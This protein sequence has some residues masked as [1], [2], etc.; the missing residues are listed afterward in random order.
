MYTCIKIIS[1]PHSARD[2]ATACPMPLVP[3]VITAVWPS[4]ENEAIVAE[5]VIFNT[6]LN[7]LNLC[8]FDFLERQLTAA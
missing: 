3:P 2:T 6:K 8:F 5:S 1:A 4:S 7:V